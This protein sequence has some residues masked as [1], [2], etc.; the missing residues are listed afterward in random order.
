MRDHPGWRSSRLWR[1]A[2]LANSPEI[3]VVSH[4]DTVH[5]VLQSEIDRL[6]AAVPLI[7]P[8]ITRSIT[9][10]HACQWIRKTK[11]ALL[12]LDPDT[13]RGDGNQ[14]PRNA[15]ALL[16]DIGEQTPV[17]IALTRSDESWAPDAILRPNIS[18][19][20]WESI[21][22]TLDGLLPR[23]LSPPS[24]RRLRAVVRL[25]WPQP[26][27]DIDLDGAALFRGLRLNTGALFCR[28]WRADNLQSVLDMVDRTACW[29]SLADKGNALFRDT[30]D[31]LGDALLEASDNGAALDLRFEIDPDDMERL[32]PLPIELLNRDATWQ[33][34]FCRV[35]PMARRVSRRAARAGAAPGDRPHVLYVDAAATRGSMKVIGTEG[36]LVNRLFGD[37]SGAVSAEKRALEDLKNFCQLEQLTPT[38]HETGLKD[39]LHDRLCDGSQPSPDIVHFTGH[40]ITP[41]FGSTELLLPS[42][43]QGEVDRLSI[44]VFASWLPA[45]VRLVVLSACQGV[46]VDTA[47]LLH[48]AKGIAVLGFRWEVQADAAAEFVENFY[49]AYLRERQ[50]MAAA[51]RTACFMGNVAQFAWAA[52]V[53]LDHD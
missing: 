30:L 10:G 6:G 20:D 14:P 2:T 48:A 25:R 39:A 41:V 47:R 21:E 50:P 52:A 49:R 3:R 29:T 19:W 35:A 51:Y 42:L 53:L 32:F 27:C 37:L 38:G 22:C 44:G 28:D 36:L 45:S 43:R 16:Q 24:H 5:D 8:R 46:S 17:L 1:R 9:L 40:A 13:P 18:V 15:H 7:G 11:P 34:F 31:D 12:V 26:V 33:K 23:L 4:N